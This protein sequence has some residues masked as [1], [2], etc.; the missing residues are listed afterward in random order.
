ME[1]SVLEPCARFHGELDIKTLGGAGFASQRTTGVGRSWDLSDYDGIEIEVSDADGKECDELHRS[2]SLYTF[3]HTAKQYTFVIKDTILPRNPDTGREQSTISYEYEFRLNENENDSRS[4]NFI[5]IPW[6][7]F[8]ATYRGKE[9]KGASPLN[10]KNIKRFS[11]MMRSFFGQQEGSFSLCIKQVLA[12]G[13]TKSMASS[14]ICSEK[15]DLEDQKYIVREN[16]LEEVTMHLYHKAENL[17]TT[18]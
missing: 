4:S 1:C 14:R 12:V 18:T 9:K 15:E 6:S 10:T 5:F 7:S 2:I 17:L 16:I 11:F 3:M 8:K 13:G